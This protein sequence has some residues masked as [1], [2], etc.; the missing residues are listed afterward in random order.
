MLFS[1]RRKL[2]YKIFSKGKQS[3]EELVLLSTY[4]GSC[5]NKKAESKVVEQGDQISL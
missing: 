3:V 5:P 1:S 4:I 2:A